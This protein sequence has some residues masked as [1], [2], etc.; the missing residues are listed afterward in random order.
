MKTDKPFPMTIEYQFAGAEG[1]TV[2][3][4]R[5]QG[6]PTGIAALFSPLM[7]I[8]VK[9]MVRRDM[10]RLKRILEARPT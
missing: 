6:R 8:M 4:Q 10:Q 1:G 9:N 3:T 2:F 5:L 7:A